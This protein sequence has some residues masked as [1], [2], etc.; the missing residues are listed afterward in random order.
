MKY[1]K[2]SKYKN[3]EVV[4][5]GAIPDKWEI[6]KI[7]FTSYVKGRIGYH[8]LRADEFIDEGPYL[9]TGTDFKNGGINWDTC[10]HVPEWRYEQDPFI[11]IKNNDV[12]ITKDGTIGKIA[13]VEDLPGKT[14]LNSHLLVLRPLKNS[15]HSRYLYWIFLTDYFTHYVNLVQSGSIMNALSQDNLENFIFTLPSPTEQQ[16]ISEFLDEKIA[17]IDQLI[18]KSKERVALLQE[19]RQVTI[20]HAVTKGLSDTVLTKDSGVDWIGNIPEHW[21]TV[22]LKYLLSLLKDGS[23]NPPPRVESGIKFIPGATNIKNSKVIF[24]NCAYI[25]KADFFEIHKSYKLQADDILLTIVAT[26]GNVAMVNEEDLPFSM[27]Q[28]IAVLR[29]NLD[30]TSKFLFYFLHSDYF[31]NSLRSRS[32]SSVKPGIYLESL[33]NIPIVVSTKL[34]EQQDISEFLDEKI[35]QI[36]QLI[37][38]SKERVALLQEKRQTLISAAVTG[39]I[40]VRN[41]VAA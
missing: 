28:S 6:N 30:I 33:G 2:Y 21:N 31:Q 29:P 1:K 19:K 41:G 17:Q 4:W 7:K 26:L 3:S 24:K 40:D 25:S 23:H 27:Q 8:G 9:I 38:K 32:H 16:D 36:D 18:I 14:T 22:K 13:F 15:Y 12:L 11:Q 39:K 5:I 37:I 10:Y 35:T 34:D 20:N